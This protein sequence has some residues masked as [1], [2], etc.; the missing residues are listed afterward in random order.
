[1]LQ[2]FLLALGC[3]MRRATHMIDGGNMNEG[4]AA[5]EVWVRHRRQYRLRGAAYC[6]HYSRVPA[7]CRS[8]LARVLAECVYFNTV[9]CLGPILAAVS[10]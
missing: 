3:G 4:R 8:S 2:L 7:A 1:M 6:F 9:L 5:L 10:Q